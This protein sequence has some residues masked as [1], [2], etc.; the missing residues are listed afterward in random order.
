[1]TFLQAA[2]LHVNF[3][4]DTFTLW[5]A[6]ATDSQSLVGVD[7]SVL[8]VLL[9]SQLLSH[10]LLDLQQPLHLRHMRQMPHSPLE[11]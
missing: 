3:D 7:Q 5:Q 8:D 2:Y 6:N 10:H 1:M 4:D 11:P 9:P